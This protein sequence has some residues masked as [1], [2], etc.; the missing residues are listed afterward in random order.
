MQLDVFGQRH[1]F[2]GGIIIQKLSSICICQY[3]PARHI[4][5][6]LEKHTA[7]RWG[8]VCTACL[9]VSPRTHILNLCKFLENLQ[10]ADHRLYWTGII[11]DLTSVGLL[12]LMEERYKEDGKIRK[13]AN[14]VKCLAAVIIRHLICVL[15]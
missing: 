13:H 10:S 15:F 5:F 9:E 6:L 7:E 2:E 12:R 4:E 11:V 1:S 3:T 14:I 8:Y